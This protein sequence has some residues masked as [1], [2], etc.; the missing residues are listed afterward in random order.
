MVIMSV[1]EIF[2]YKYVVKTLAQITDGIVEIHNTRFS[3][4]WIS[5]YFYFNQYYFGEPIC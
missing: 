3:S 1:Y 4:V 5:V 2:I